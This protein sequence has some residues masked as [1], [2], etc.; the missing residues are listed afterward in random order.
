MLVLDAPA[1]AFA[2]CFGLKWAKT[3]VGSEIP[4]MVSTRPDFRQAASSPLHNHSFRTRQPHCLW[5]EHCSAGLDRLPE[6]GTRRP[7]PVV[8]P[9]Y[10]TDANRG[11]VE[12]C[13]Y[14]W[15]YRR[16]SLAVLAD[17]NIRIPANIIGGGSRY[18]RQ[19]RAWCDKDSK[20]DLLKRR[21]RGREKRDFRQADRSARHDQNGTKT[22][23][24]G[25]FGL[26]PISG[27]SDQGAA[28]RADDRTWSV[29]SATNIRKGSAA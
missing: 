8:A 4:K 13:I 21:M 7:V 10:V 17:A 27:S 12:H 28:L 2:R 23:S 25:I 5:S 14:L 19:N 6:P 1:I 29:R 16:T 11:V 24:D 15:V 26:G 3:P 22:E 18:L 20:L 9:I